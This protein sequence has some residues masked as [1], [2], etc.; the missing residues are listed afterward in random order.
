MLTINGGD[1]LTLYEI[2]QQIENAIELGFDPETGEILDASALEQLQMDFDEKVE[3][4]LLYIKNLLAE[5]EAI[6]AEQKAL[7]A[8]KKSR[9]RRAEYLTNYVQNVLD[10]KKFISAK[11]ETTYRKVQS[12]VVDDFESIPE[13]YLRIKTVSEPDKTAIKDAIKS[14]AEIA[15]AHLEERQSMSI[16]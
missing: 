13:E 12:V 10:G 11:C 8:R 6:D 1:S 7:D 5:A 15:G 2:D 16:K 9:K 3:N 4:T 14:G